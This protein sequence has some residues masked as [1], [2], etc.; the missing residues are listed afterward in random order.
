MAKND[1]HITL[2]H[3][4]GGQ[5]THDLIERMLLPRFDNPALHPLEDSALL[6]GRLAFT[7][8]SFVVSPL[9]FPG[10]DIGK[11]AVCGT[12]ND[13][14]VAGARPRW[15][16]CG[17]IIEEGFARVD[18]ET[19]LDSMA[20]TAREVGAQIV[21]GDTKVVEHGSADGLFINTAGV[22]ERYEMYEPSAPRPGDAILVSGPV[23]DH[24]A[25][26]FHARE[27]VAR[28][29]HVTSD[30]AALWPLVEA[31]MQHAVHIR[32]MHDP[33]R[34][35]LATV[36]CET[37]QRAGCSF[38]IDE[39]AVPVRHEVEGLCE[40]VGFDPLYMAC[41]GR[42]VAVV[43]ADAAEAILAT[44]RDH[45]LGEEA[46]T[47]GRVLD[48]AKG[49]CYLKTAVGGSRVLRML[50]AQQLPRIC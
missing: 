31:M 17:L 38:E 20:D 3:G 11:L 40:L 16:S 2:G 48:E 42:L 25:A 12:V 32:T 5:L 7:T 39:A 6:P 43:A 24:E 15:I 50:A 49:A 47:I 8:D 36:L 34:G 18:L 41:E 9:F 35:G 4:S 1:E 46:A 33:T 37:A 27:Q 28:R 44:M 29:L 45:P 22:G 30:C 26:I 14:A 10:G 23:G 19:I 21:T 13:L